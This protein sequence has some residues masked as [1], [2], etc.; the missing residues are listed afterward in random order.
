MFKNWDRI[1]QTRDMQDEGK[2]GSLKGLQ[3]A[4]EGATVK[5]GV[6]PEG[7]EGREGR[8]GHTLQ[9]GPEKLS[10]HIPEPQA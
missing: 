5:G 3:R 9:N 4:S 6:G 8:R 2:K 1:L 7:G 10:F